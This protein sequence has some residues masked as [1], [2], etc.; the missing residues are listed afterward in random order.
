M[1]DPQSYAAEQRAAAFVMTE[2]ALRLK[3]D[4]LLEQCGREA[5]H[6]VPGHGTPVGPYLHVSEIFMLLGL[7]G[8]PSYDAL[9]DGIAAATGI[10]EEITGPPPMQVDPATFLAALGYCADGSCGTCGACRLR[11]E[12]QGQRPNR[13]KSGGRSDPCPFCPVD[14]GGHRRFFDIFTHFTEVHPNG[15][16]TPSGGH[17]YNDGAG[18]LWEHPGPV[19]H[20]TAIECIEEGNRS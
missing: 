7:S 18:G 5:A 15:S 11:A 4:I 10:P 17:V 13:P 8:A 9:R 3:V 6:P 19:E 2:A 1:T 16:P 12:E 14:G 20:C